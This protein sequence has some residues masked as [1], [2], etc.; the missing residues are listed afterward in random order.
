MWW[1]QPKSQQQGP[2]GQPRDKGTHPAQ[3]WQGGWNEKRQRLALP[4]LT[5][6]G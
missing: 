2:A 4:A 5:L 6:S 1:S 3:L